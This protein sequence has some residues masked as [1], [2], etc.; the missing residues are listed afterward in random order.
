MVYIGFFK[1]ILT[2]LNNFR[3]EVDLY[4][5]PCF[6]ICVVIYVVLMAMNDEAMRCSVGRL[7]AV[8]F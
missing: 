2:F 5:C 6:N 3:S 7:I 8:I 1:K 4:D